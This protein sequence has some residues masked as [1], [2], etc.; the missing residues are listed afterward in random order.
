MRAEAGSLDEA[1]FSGYLNGLRDAGWQ[2]DRR[3]RASG[4]HH[5][6]RITLGRGGPVVVAVLADSGKQAELETHWNRPL[7]ELI[8]QWA[9][10]TTYI[11]WRRRLIGSR[12]KSMLKS[13]SRFWGAPCND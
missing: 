11:P 10:T 2:G 6:V 13:D 7:E 1:V 3:T 12:R 4:L 9:K 8:L 5:C